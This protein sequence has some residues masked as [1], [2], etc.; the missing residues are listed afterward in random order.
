MDADSIDILDEADGDHLIFRIAHDFHFKLFP[1]EDRLLNEAL[2]SQR[3]VKP[4]LAD[5]A[6]LF[7][8][9]AEAAAAAAHRIRRTHHNGIADILLN[10][11]NGLFHRMDDA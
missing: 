2:A 6:E 8:V 3:S 7:N 1:V 9:V 11:L 5:R 10:K 4:A